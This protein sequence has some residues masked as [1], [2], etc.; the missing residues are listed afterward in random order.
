VV[1]DASGGV[2]PGVT[3]EVA[4]P[5]LI[6]KTRSDVTDASG[7]YRIVNLLLCRRRIGCL[8]RRV[9]A[10]VLPE[11]LHRGMDELATF[12]GVQA[13]RR[14]RPGLDAHPVACSRANEV[15]TTVPT[16]RSWAATAC[17][18]GIIIQ[19]GT[20]AD[21]QVTP[22]MTVFGGRAGARR[23]RMQV[24]GLSTGAALNG[25]GVSTYVADISNAAEVVTTTSGSMGER[26]GGLAQHRAKSGGNTVRARFI[27]PV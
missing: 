2:L 12:P 21:I 26:V 3:V 22:Q 18:S 6:E 19:A 9:R 20:S 5:V 16:A 11:F 15:L 13:L 7:L 23:G 10:Q 25:G 4:S 1:K 24:D 17:C 27:C 14:F 8:Q